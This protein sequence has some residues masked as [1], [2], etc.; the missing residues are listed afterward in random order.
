MPE[1]LFKTELSFCADF[2]VYKSDIGVGAYRAF[3]FLYKGIIIK[4]NENRASLH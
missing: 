3:R 4:H 2:I 1:G